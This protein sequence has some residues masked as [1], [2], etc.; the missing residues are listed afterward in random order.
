MIGLS[1]FGLKNQSPDELLMARWDKLGSRGR[2]QD[3][4]GMAGPAVG[5]IG[6]S[7]IVLVLA[8]AYFGGGEQAAQV[9]EVIQEVNQQSQS[10]GV[11]GEQAA[12]FAG[13]DSYEVFASTVL[14]SNNDMWRD[15][16]ARSGET[17]REPTLVL[18]RGRT[19]SGCG[20]A[21]SAV[22]PHYCPLDETI[23]IDETFFEEL[24]S[25]FGA[26]GGDVA[27]AYVMAHEVGHH[28]QTVLGI[29]DE[30]RSLQQRSPRNANEISINQELQADCFAGLWAYSLQDQG[31]FELGEIEEAIDAAEAV[32]DD[33]IQ[34]TVNGR[35]N[36]ESWTHGSSA[37]RKKWFNTGYETGEFARCDTFAI[38]S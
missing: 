37:E 25:R 2:V 23:Y 5:G 22:G 16:F 26:R 28:V 13:E 4:R 6:I 14:G 18:F 1:Y 19:K 30:A 36:P 7:G 12:E 31:V 33:R 15:V 34:E 24:Q 27:E 9:A 21:T 11:S 10:Q 20:G 29:A 8:V 35:I 3:R 38:R 32:G 17:Y